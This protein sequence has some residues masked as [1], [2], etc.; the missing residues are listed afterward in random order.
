LKIEIDMVVEGCYNLGLQTKENNMSDF[1]AGDVVE[2]LGT[3]GYITDGGKYST[4]KEYT[5]GFVDRDGTF[6]ILD[7]EGDDTYA[8]FKDF[9]KI[10]NT[11][12][13]TLSPNEAQALADVLTLVDGYMNIS[14]VTYT[15]SIQDKLKALGFE[16]SEIGDCSG[17]IYF[18]QTQEETVEYDGKTYNKAA[19]DA[20]LNTLEKL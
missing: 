20:M 19:F 8:D 10:T 15:E 1:K 13:L 3:S 9:K 16:Q 17:S 2:W 14:R 11:I 18:E 5:V 4:N 7:D 12:S 6:L